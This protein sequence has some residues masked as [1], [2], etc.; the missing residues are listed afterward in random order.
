MCFYGRE[1]TPLHRAARRNEFGCPGYP[2]PNRRIL[3]TFSAVFAGSH[4]LRAFFGEAKPVSI[5]RKHNLWGGSREEFGTTNERSVHRSCP[6]AL[7]IPPRDVYRRR[8]AE[9]G[10]S[11]NPSCYFFTVVP[12]WC[13][14]YSC[15]CP[16]LL[17]HESALSSGHHSLWL[18][19]KPDRS[20][21]LLAT[22]QATSAANPKN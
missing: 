11:E 6:V 3:G 19:A 21:S 14:P 16:L 4:F 8:L 5:E 10:G 20:S 13:L 18:H 15:C 7:Y 2:Y 9:E 22:L 12:C 17:T 1:H